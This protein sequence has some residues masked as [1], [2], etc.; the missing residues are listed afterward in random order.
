MGR[1]KQ[2]RPTRQAP[3]PLPHS[4]LKSLRKAGP[5]LLPALP[6]K[7]RAPRRERGRRRLPRPARLRPMRR[8]ASPLTETKEPWRALAPTVWCERMAEPLPG[9]KI[10]PFAA[11]RHYLAV[12]PPPPQ[13]FGVRGIHAT[14]RVSQ[15]RG[16]HFAKLL[17]WRDT[18]VSILFHVYPQTSRVQRTASIGATL[19]F[20]AASSPPAS[21]SASTLSPCR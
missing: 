21:G 2:E 11:Q 4:R 8:R 20:Y 1:K 16:R 12:S 7:K 13:R 9:W 3:L 6:R 19:P 15:R 5:I 10:P 14:R 17:A 18:V